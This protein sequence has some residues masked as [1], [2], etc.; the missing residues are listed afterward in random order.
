MTYR[1]N[2]EIAKR[3]KSKRWQKLRKEK[4]LFNPLC[5]RCLKKSLYIAAYFVHHK[6]YVTNKNYMNDDIFFSID[7]LES[8]CKKCHNEEHFAEKDEYIFDENGDLIKND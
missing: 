8:L 6:V 2:P 3:Y 4:L 7:N 1:D 5:E